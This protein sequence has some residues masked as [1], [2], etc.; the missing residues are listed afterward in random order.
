MTGVQTCALP[1]L[2]DLGD[3]NAVYRRQGFYNAVDK[4]P[5]L[6]EKPVEIPSKWDANTALSNI[7]SAFEAHPEIDFLFTS[8]DFL[9]PQIKAVLAPLGKWVPAG[10]EGHI[11]LGGL[12]GDATACRLMEEG[13][14]DATGVQDLYAEADMLLTALLEAIEKGEKTPTNWMDDPGFALTQANMDDRKM[15]MWGCKLLAKEREQSRQSA[16][17]AED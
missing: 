1:I 9:Y 11:I 13:I 15:D 7:R 17:V 5:D 16:T 3:P 2:G 8:S 14:V 12:D 10:E 4:E 6:F